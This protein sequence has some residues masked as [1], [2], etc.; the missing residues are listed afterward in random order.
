VDIPKQVPK[1]KYSVMAD[2]KSKDGE[3]VTCMMSEILFS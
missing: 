1:G 2:V 3:A